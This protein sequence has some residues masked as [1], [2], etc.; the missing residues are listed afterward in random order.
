MK[1]KRTLIA[2]AVLAAASGSVFAGQLKNP[3]LF[4]AT[5]VGEQIGIEG[6]VR[7]FGCVSVSST[8]GAVVNNTQNVYAHASLDPQSQSYMSGALTTRVNNATNSVTGT[9]SNSVWANSSFST[10]DSHS[11]SHSSS[12]SHSANSTT[13]ISTSSNYAYANQAKASASSEYHQSSDSGHASN[14]SSSFDAG[15][16]LSDNSKHSSSQS[17]N[18]SGKFSEGAS[19]ST[20]YSS[21]GKNWGGSKEHSTSASE[22]LQAHASGSYD[23]NHMSSASDSLN[24]NASGHLNTSHSDTESQHKNASQSGSAQA[25]NSGSGNQS[26]SATVTYAH[27]DSKSSS[28]SHSGSSSF[29]TSSSASKNWGYNVNDTLTT[30]DEKTTGSV[31]QYINTQAPGTLNAGTGSNAASGVS[32]NLGINIAEGI[33]N[34]QSNDVALASVDVGN[35]FG[36]AQIFNSQGSGGSAKINNFNLNASVGDGSLSHVTGNVGVNVASGIG[37]VQNNSLA[38]AVTTTNAGTAMTTAM[39]ATDDNSQSANMAVHGQFQG[40]A[41]LGA[42][43]LAGASGNIGVNIAGGAGNLQH[44]GL[45]IA[46]LNSGH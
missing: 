18:F 1:L 14:S 22:N 46:A 35:V 45:A 7:L 20:S 40:T 4:N 37:N 44:N 39:V 3:Y 23:K 25:S 43:T 36:N 24:A 11:S 41:M 17:G 10:S 29:S 12:N 42:N 26:A 5:M 6:F 19:A 2:A 21:H 13:T 28:A 32:G 34:A 16:A 15:I 8:A 27:N 38:G 9:G 33:D 31:T 30:V